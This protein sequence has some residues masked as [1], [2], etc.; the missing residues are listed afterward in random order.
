MKKNTKK[1]IA[2]FFDSKKFAV[3]G[4]S[5]ES[6]KF[7]RLVYQSMKKKGYPVV[8][9]NP[10][11]AE[12]GGD[13]CYQA[14]EELPPGVDALIVLT[15]EKET[16]EVVKKA[17]AKNIKKIWIQQESENAE[18]I[19]FAEQEGILLIVHECILMFME[20]VEGIHKFHRWVKNIF[21]ANPR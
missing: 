19:A 16:T 6:S 15:K 5:R 18:T 21:G 4:V 11:A 12:I 17:I 9:I 13:K 8:P 14:V 3:A 20:P 1:E 10:Q 2:D 7:G